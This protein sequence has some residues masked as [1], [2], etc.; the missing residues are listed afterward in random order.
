MRTLPAVRILAIIF[1]GFMTGILLGDRLGPTYARPE[2]SPADFVILQQVTHVHYSKV[3]PVYLAI[4]VF[5]AFFWLIL[6]RAQRNRLHFWLLALALIFIAS[7][8]YVTIHF[9]FPINAQLMTWNSSS[10][11]ANFKRIWSVW[12]NAYSI[13]TILWVLAFVLEVTALSL[14]AS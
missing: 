10:P 13:R 14:A 12:E 4:S 1:C 6:I 5:A 11:P 8:A 7:A 9:N 2:L 3:L